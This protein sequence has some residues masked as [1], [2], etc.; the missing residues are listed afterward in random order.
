MRTT[1]SRLY[2][3]CAVLAG[4]FLISIAVLI[5]IQASGRWLGVT[6]QG[7]SDYAG[8]CMAAASFLAM[9][10]TFGRGGHI[11][12]TIILQ[13]LGPRARRIMEFWCLGAGTYLS[14]YFAFYSI[15]MVRVSYKIGDISQA[16]DA[17]PLWI[18]QIGMAVGTSVLAIAMAEKLFDLARGGAVETDAPPS[19]ETETD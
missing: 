19:L 5:L 9:A 7:A 3:G 8:Y 17:T 13:K 2:T 15:K 4:L 18:P 12:V 11:R 10:H 14:A 16:A 1:L 6:V